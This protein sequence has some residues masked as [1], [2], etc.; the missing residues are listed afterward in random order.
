M[1]ALIE[2][3]SEVIDT[4]APLTGDTLLEAIPEYD[5][6]AVLMLLNW[7]DARGIDVRPADFEKFRTVGDNLALLKA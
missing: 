2:E 6:M 1:S 5:S 3:F 4:S 7:L